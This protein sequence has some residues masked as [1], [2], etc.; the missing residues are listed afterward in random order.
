MKIISLSILA[1]L[2]LGM[3][4]G[5]LLAQEPNPK[6][7]AGSTPRILAD[8]ETARAESNKKL[9]AAFQKAIQSVEKSESIS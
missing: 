5:R 8:I 3:N 2:V 6:A 4:S 9:E 1:S 7:P